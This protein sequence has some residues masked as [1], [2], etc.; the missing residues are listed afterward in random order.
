MI[1]NV[2]RVLTPCREQG[3]YADRTFLNKE[4]KEL[5]RKELDLARAM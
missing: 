2:F 4:L 1:V 3:T 5:T